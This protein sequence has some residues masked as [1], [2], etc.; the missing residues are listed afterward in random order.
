MPAEQVVPKDIDE[1]IAG[2]AP[3]VR[4]LL[5]SV[6]LT[7]REAVPE[8]QETIKYGMP[9]F[10][11]RGNLVYFAAFQK[12]LSLFGASPEA[13]A[14][15]RAELAGCIGPKGA[16]KFS[17]ARPLPLDL[18]ARIVLVMALANRQRAEARKKE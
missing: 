7:I 18:I 2:F 6:R 3:E 5:Q 17:Y 1:Y 14:H 4:E 12:H 16:L 11:L 15:F 8:A 13:I 10:T 9:T